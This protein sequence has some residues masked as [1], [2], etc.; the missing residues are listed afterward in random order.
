MPRITRQQAEL[1]IIERFQSAFVKY[2]GYALSEI[3]HQDRPDFTAFDPRTKETIGI[4]ITGV[5]QDSYEARIQYWDM[6]KWGRFT[7][8]LSDLIESLNRVL[9]DKAI[10]SW[11]YKFDGRLIL[12]VF[13]GSLIY[14][15]KRDI[16]FMLNKIVIPK[17]R[18][19]DIWLIL[20]NQIDNSPEFYILK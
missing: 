7:S 4:E 15:E 6:E 8:S 19:T 2:F 1:A 10:K 20:E 5:Y 13:I 9:D 3:H 12:G 14:N 11:D 18:F 17:S 16:D